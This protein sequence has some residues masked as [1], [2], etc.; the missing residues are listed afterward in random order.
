MHQLHGVESGEEKHLLS[1]ESF[2]TSEEKVLLVE[3][4]SFMESQ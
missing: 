2:A 1:E 4:G 3:M